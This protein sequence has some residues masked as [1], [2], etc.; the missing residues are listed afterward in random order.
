MAL[1]RFRRLGKLRSQMVDTERENLFPIPRARQRS[2]LVDL[3]HKAKAVG[4]THIP[5]QP[6][7]PNSGSAGC[8][9][10]GISPRFQRR[11][12]PTMED[13]P[14]L[15]KVQIPNASDSTFEQKA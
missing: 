13:S 15:V 10:A 7:N 14:L 11:C 2:Q 6:Q 12:A 5:F 8:Y 1:E 4:D 9:V 3:I